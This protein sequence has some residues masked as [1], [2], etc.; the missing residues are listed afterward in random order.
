[1]NGFSALHSS[2]ILTL[3]QPTVAIFIDHYN[4]HDSIATYVGKYYYELGLLLKESSKY[5]SVV[6]K[7]LFAHSSKLPEKYIQDCDKLGF[8]IVHCEE[9]HNGNGSMKSLADGEIYCNVVDTLDRYPYISTYVII[10]SDVD[11]LPLIRKIRREGKQVTLIG[12][13][14]NMKQ[15]LVDECERLG[16]KRIR[17][18]DLVRAEER[19]AKITKLAEVPANRTAAVVV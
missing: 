12:T 11:F 6:V 8:E 1:M 19:E 13:S 9:Y 14:Q 10:S 3:N 18:N 5:G 4:L 7:E 16:V 15:R 17:Y 2:S